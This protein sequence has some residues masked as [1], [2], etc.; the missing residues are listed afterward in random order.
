MQVKI[1]S[2]IGKITAENQ[3]TIVTVEPSQ[4]NI[5]QMTIPTVSL[6]PVNNNCSINNLTL[7][8]GYS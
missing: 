1:Q 7:P 8:Y 6:M 4:L 3:R 5:R 2:T